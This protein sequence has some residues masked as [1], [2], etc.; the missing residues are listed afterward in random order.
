MGKKNISLG[1]MAL[2]L[3]N[4]PVM[5]LNTYRS[6]AIH[7]PDMALDVLSLNDTCGVAHHSNARCVHGSE[8]S[9]GSN[10]DGPKRAIRKKER[11]RASM[12]DCTFS[13]RP[14]SSLMIT[15][16]GSKQSSAANRRASIGSKQSPIVK[17]RTSIGSQSL[18]ANSRVSIGSQSPTAKK[19]TSRKK[20]TESSGDSSSKRD[21]S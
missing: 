5:I 3:D 20:K 14:S 11:R 6:N 12:S 2:R 7:C 16:I 4:P 8:L 19:K 1:R 9:V 15:T 17:R 21:T 18:T 10:N 13:V